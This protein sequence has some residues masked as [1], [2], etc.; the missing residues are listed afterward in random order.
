MPDKDAPASTPVPGCMQS[1][2]VGEVLFSWRGDMETSEWLAECELV[3]ATLGIAPEMNPARWARRYA[4]RR[5]DAPL[6]G[7]I[8]DMA[9][10][11]VITDYERGKIITS[12]HA[13]NCGYNILREVCEART[14]AWEEAQASILYGDPAP[15]AP[16]R[17]AVNRA[18]DREIWVN[19][20]VREIMRGWWDQSWAKIVAI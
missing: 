19:Q 5:I 1:A 4:V 13:Q 17:D 8:A 9:I 14:Q 10:V 2:L 20:R 6:G 11:W 7:L 16:E 15:G 18:R 3:S 12:V